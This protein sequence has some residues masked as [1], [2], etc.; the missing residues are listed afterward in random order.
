M[1]HCGAMPRLRCCWLS[2]EIAWL[3]LAL[4]AHPINAASSN[5]KP[6]VGFTLPWAG[7]TPAPNVKEVR[8]RIWFGGVEMARLIG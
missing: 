8:G 1:S 4:G 5:V 2:A 6:A 3:V 7:V